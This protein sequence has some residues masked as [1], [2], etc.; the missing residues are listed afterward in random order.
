MPPTTYE[1][2]AIRYA[3]LEQRQRSENFLIKDSLHDGSMPMDYFVWL[4]Q[5]HDR[6]FLVDT[7]FNAD[8]A[9]ERKRTFMR[10]PIQS[11]AALGLNP[12]SIS[13]LILTHLHYDHAGNL[14]KLQSA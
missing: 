8:V 3:T 9:L 5:S 11:L 4:I 13:D 10:C 12:A 14:N 7:G 1:V 2:Y 6:R